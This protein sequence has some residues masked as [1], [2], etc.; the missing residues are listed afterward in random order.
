VAYVRLGS[1][2]DIPMPFAHSRFGPEADIDNY[3]YAPWP[4]A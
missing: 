4:N 3:E 2:G 1:K